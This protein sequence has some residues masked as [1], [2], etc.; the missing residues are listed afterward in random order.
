MPVVPTIVP[1]HHVIPAIII[2][3]MVHVLLVLLYMHLVRRH[4]LY[5][6]E[7][8]HIPPTVVTC[9]PRVAPAAHITAVI[10][11]TRVPHVMLDLRAARR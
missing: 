11:H 4:V 1:R 3:P 7:H 5:L 8:V 2:T 9:I 6:V 10:A